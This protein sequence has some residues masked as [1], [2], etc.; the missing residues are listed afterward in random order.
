[1]NA[2]TTQGKAP[3]EEH[4]HGAKVSPYGLFAFQKE[5]NTSF[6]FFHLT[7]AL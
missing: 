5:P 7:L 1:M 6:S 4:F 3:A 2:K